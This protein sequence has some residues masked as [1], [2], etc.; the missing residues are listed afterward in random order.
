M[1]TQYPLLYIVLVR[2]AYP[3]TRVVTAHLTA[4]TTQPHTHVCL[5]TLVSGASG[6][7][8]VAHPFAVCVSRFAIETGIKIISRKP[9]TKKRYQRLRLIYS[10]LIAFLD[11]RFPMDS[12][13][14]RKAASISARSRPIAQL[15][16]AHVAPRSAL[17]RAVRQPASPDGVDCRTL[18]PKLTVEMRAD[19]VLWPQRVRVRA[20]ALHEQCVDVLDLARL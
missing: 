17:E 20:V 9:Q 3:G 11:L 18:R 14:Q 19:H 4:H 10:S 13:R 15:D 8:G 6:R 1:C 2:E 12:L 5:S 7:S 16:L